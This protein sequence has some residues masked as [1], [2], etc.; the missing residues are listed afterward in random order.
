MPWYCGRLTKIVTDTTITVQH[1]IRVPVFLNESTWKVEITEIV[2][3]EYLKYIERHFH[4]DKEDLKC[5]KVD[6][7]LPTCYI[8]KQNESLKKKLSERK[9][10]KSKR[11][12]LI[13]LEEL[14]TI[15]QLVLHCYRNIPINRLQ[16]ALIRYT[17]SKV[18]GY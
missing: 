18:V 6:R 9:E 17:L 16:F 13:E 8:T 12:L 1:Y 5:Y 3:F 7:R 10:E 2:C 14:H 15:A 11:N 4:I